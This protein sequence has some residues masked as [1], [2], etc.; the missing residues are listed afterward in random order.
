MEGDGSG[1]INH[2]NNSAY[3]IHPSWSPNGQYMAFSTNRDGNREIYVM[4]ADGTDL[5]RITDHPALD[6]RPVW[7]PD[8]SKIAFHTYRDGNWEIYVMNPD[9]S[10]P[11]NLT[12][13]SGDDL[14]PTWAHDGSQLAFRSERDG[15]REIYVMNSHDGSGQTNLT[16]HPA[17]DDLPAWSPDGTKIA[18]NSTR[19]SDPDPEVYAAEIYVMD[20][21]GTNLTRLTYNPAHDALPAWSPN[22]DYI[23]FASQRRGDWEVYVMNAD[24]TQPTNISNS[25]GS[26]D[27]NPAWRPPEGPFGPAR[28]VEVS[29]AGATVTTGTQAFTAQAYDWFGTPMAVGGETWTSRNP[30]MAT[31]GPTGVATGVMS[32]QVHIAADV[33]GVEGY[34]LLTV[35]KPEPAPVTV[36]APVSSPAPGAELT[37]LWAVAPDDI[38]AV[39]CPNTTLRF[40][41]SDWEVI[42]GGGTCAYHWS[43]FGV[44]WGTAPDDIWSVGRN[45]V[46]RHY[47]GT[48]WSLFTDYPPS[49]TQV[50]AAWGAAPDDIWGVG[51]DG[52]LLHFDGNEWTGFPSPVGA[53]VR[54]VGIWG[55]AAD[56]IWA[57]AYSPP[58]GPGTIIHYDGVS[59]DLAATTTSGLTWIWG[60]APDDVW[61]L[62]YDGLIIHY[63]GSIWQDVTSPTTDVLIGVWGAAADDVWIAGDC[64]TILHW[65]GASWSIVPSPTANDLFSVWGAEDLWA[66][67]SAGTILR[68][69]RGATVTVAPTHPTLGPGDDVQM[70]GEAR[71]ASSNLIANVSFMWT[72]DNP[73]VA[74][75]T[76]SGLVTATGTGTATITGTATGGASASAT[77]TVQPTFGGTLSST[78]LDFGERLLVQPSP[79]LPWDGDEYVT[80]GGVQSSW[81]YNDMDSIA[82]VVPRLPTGPAQLVVH[83][84]GPSQVT[85]HAD[86][87]VAS[88][89]TPNSDPLSGVDISAGPFPMWFYI[90]LSDTESDHWLTLAP[91]SD[92][93]VTVRLRWETVADLDILW[94]NEDATAWTGNFNGATA[95]MPEESTV[96]IPG[97]TTYRLWLDLYDSQGASPTLAQVTITSP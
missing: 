13:H 72:S 97:G 85:Q 4:N 9:G 96:T 31:V 69:Y 32:G 12:N 2:T 6:S 89:F 81:A 20:S 60:A 25:P 17:H 95:S 63:N 38:W 92:L 35:A 93:T 86:V 28:S 49:V 53:G 84:Q 61:A 27:A 42:E 5:T 10:E 55:S 75:V 78:S 14:F 29:P 33:D 23:A 40:E 66:A 3:D 74:T 71:D 94:T 57:V 46:M 37:S 52:L 26:W 44:L 34:G 54:L 39:G 16:N 88:T 51:R 1:Q 58:G 7:S 41:G 68:G 43:D 50:T 80:I 36:W 11:K 76:Q 15:N 59:W 19:D 21:D 64:G 22:G 65:D 45:P 56:D 83:N 8:G 30:N 77:V 87:D 67:G 82:L 24:G 70:I 18:F 91:S 79:T 47:N 73:A 90:E 48:D 62:G